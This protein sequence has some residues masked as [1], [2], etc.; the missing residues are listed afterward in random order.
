MYIHRSF[1]IEKSQTIILN[2]QKNKF[3]FGNAYPILA[4]IALTRVLCRRYLRGDISEE[5]WEF[6]KKEPMFTAGPINLRPYLD[7]NWLEQGGISNVSLAINFYR[8]PLSHALGSI[9]TPVSRNGLAVVQE[10]P[11]K[12]QVP[13]SMPYDK[14]EGSPVYEPSVFHGASGCH[15]PSSG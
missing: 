11:L 15:R 14:E 1:S 7:K 2:C 13:L 8:Y 5:E 9:F 12:R 10:S 4:Q 6:R 3:T